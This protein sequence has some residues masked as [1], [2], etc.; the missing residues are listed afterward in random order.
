MEKEIAK[1][2]SEALSFFGKTN[3][4]I[5]HELKNILAI[6]SETLG[7]IDELME[8]SESGM[9]LEPGKLRS[10][11]ESVIEE[12]ERANA[13]IRNMN[14]FAHS[15][16]ELIWEVDVGQAVSLVVALSQLDSSWKN[17]KLHLVDS[18]PS[19]IYTSPILL[20]VFKNRFSYIS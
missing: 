14:T 7:L 12:I 17:T 5:S 15:V 16:D 18:K 9:A 4:L 1:S 3:R 2:Y 6:I 8:L 20:E 19:T 11:S 10:L 13:I